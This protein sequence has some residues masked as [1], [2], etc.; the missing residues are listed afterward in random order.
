MLTPSGRKY[1]LLIL[2]A[3]AVRAGDQAT[4]L[5]VQA[6]IPLYHA[7]PVIEGFFN[8]IHIHNPGGAFGFLAGQDPVLRA[9]LFLAA[10]VLAVG[11]LLVFFH[12]TPPGHP[13]LGT[14]FALI[15][16]GALG[17]L[18]DRL[19][20]GRVIDFL[21][22]HVGRYH[23][24]AFNLADSAITVGIGIFLVLMLSRRLPEDRRG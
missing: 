16:G 15:L 12:R 24:P 4:K 11:L 13:W 8:L 18:V 5:L 9:I 10:T 17:N 14:A 21:D 23:W 2:V 3:G 19:R 20:M 6:R 22:V 7:I 1:I